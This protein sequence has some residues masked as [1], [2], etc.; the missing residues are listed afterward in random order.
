MRMAYIFSIF[1]FV[2]FLHNAGAIFFL[3]NFYNEDMISQKSNVII[4]SSVKLNTT[5]TPLSVNS[6]T[7]YAL[8]KSAYSLSTND[9]SSSPEKV[10]NGTNTTGGWD[11]A[12]GE[13]GASEKQWIV[14][15]LQTVKTFNN[16]KIYW[17]NAYAKKYTI[18]I[19][20]DSAVWTTI[21][22]NNNADGGVD[23]LLVDI[24]TARY[25]RINCYERVNDLWGYHIY[26]VEVYK[27]WYNNV[28][29]SSTNDINALP[30]TIFDGNLY[31][32]WDSAH[33][34]AGAD[35]DQWIMVDFGESKKFNYIKIYWENAY[36]RSYKI[37]VSD[38]A[39]SW[40]TIL[41]LTECTGGT[42]EISFPQQNKRYVRFYF[43]ERVNDAWGYHPY[44][45]EFYN[46]LY[47]KQGYFVSK[48]ITNIYNPEWKKLYY[49]ASIPSDS[50]ANVFLINT[51][52][53]TL[54]KKKLSNGIN[55]FD[56]SSINTTNLYVGFSLKPSADEFNTP[57]VYGYAV[58]WNSVS[59]D[60]SINSLRLFEQITSLSKDKTYQLNVISLKW[61]Q[62]NLS[63][64]SNFEIYRSGSAISEDSILNGIGMYNG[65]SKLAVLSSL[66]SNYNDNTLE[67]I[68]KDNYYALCT[69]D[70][71][72]FRHVS[73]NIKI[74]SYPVE[75]PEGWVWLRAN[76]MWR[77][78]EDWDSKDTG[79]MDYKS[80]ASDGVCL[81][82]SW[83]GWAEYKIN[84]EQSMNDAYVFIRYAVWG[85]HKMS[86]YVDNIF[87]GEK[88]FVDTRDWNKFAFDYIRL[89]SLSAGKH[90]L[91]FDPD[92]SFNFD[93]FY[94]YDGYFEPDNTL[95]NGKIVAAAPWK[96]R[97][98]LISK[99]SALTSK[100][101]YDVANNPMIKNTNVISAYNY[102]VEGI[103]DVYFAKNIPVNIYFSFE[104]LPTTIDA[105][106]LSIFYWDNL[107]WIKLDSSITVDNNNYIITAYVNHF[108]DFAVFESKDFD[109]DKK[110]WW[111]YNPFSPNSDGIC[112]N[113]E[114]QFFLDNS[115]SVSVK[116][117]D[118]TGRIVRILLDCEQRTGGEVVSVKWNGKD[119]Y[120]EKLE[121]GIY[122]YQI[123]LKGI[124][125]KILNG[126]IVVVR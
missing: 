29:A 47:N 48:C 122:L 78:A 75:D 108:S 63:N 27:L 62:D 51:A 96:Q 41:M 46:A 18:Q 87:K 101:K 31:F 2:I 33:G 14:I 53:V 113:T 20:D 50:E 109:S 65:I 119:D 32:G 81:G 10:L 5:L 11:S 84:L 118:L 35:E 60:Y 71:N 44:E 103:D 15:D 39:V 37:Q 86:V 55:N 107:H 7:N 23:D 77:E 58:N 88:E 52:S 1:Y 3:E 70:K 72:G 25:I 114:L 22:S 4:S 89:G 49:Y 28:V 124:D 61:E 26:E 21:Y 13:N 42:E 111:T 16:I 120:G 57:V 40:E 73:N 67:D 100:Q 85:A 110:A 99:L 79:G 36:A 97:K 30:D 6:P 64:I 19:S 59:N 125:S 76:W 90:T 106:R 24:H 38:D 80:N 94:L 123:E 95:V 69:V 9:S 121:A 117:Y 83:Y 104:D 92:N 54:L 66:I 105:D 126:T 43:Y 115:A 112:D 12:H 91:K 102:S 116:I 45:V 68:E 93:G 56:I 17:E 8:N 34:D 82:G 74:L 98:I